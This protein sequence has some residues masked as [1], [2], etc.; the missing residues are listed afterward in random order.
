MEKATERSLATITEDDL[1][2]LLYLAQEDLASFFQRNPKYN[3][4]SGNECLV[5]LGQGA[6]LHYIDKKNGVKD[7]DV[8]FFYPRLNDTVLPF[9]RMGKVDFGESKFGRH[10]DF[11]GLMGRKIDVLMRS[12]V[13]FNDGDPRECLFGYLTDGTTTTAQM[14]SQKAMIGLY[15]EQYFGQ[16]LWREGELLR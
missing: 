16:I 3:S 8:W 11:K 4:Y 9:R 6:A 13:H 10:P 2:R 1:K 5:A 12:D 7:F 15:P 14:L